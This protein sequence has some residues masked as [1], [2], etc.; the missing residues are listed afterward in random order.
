VWTIAESEPLLGVRACDA[1]K[2]L[3]RINADAGQF[4]PDTIRRVE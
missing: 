4:F 3:T 2:D 1:E